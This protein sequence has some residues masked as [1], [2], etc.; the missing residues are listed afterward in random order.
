MALTRL[1]CHDTHYDATDGFT[2]TPGMRLTLDPATQSARITRLTNSGVFSTDE[3]LDPAAPGPIGS[4]VPNTGAFT[5]LLADTDKPVFHR[6]NVLGTVSQ[7]GGDPTGAVVERGNNANGRYVRF[8]D[9]TQ[10]CTYEVTFDT[11][12]SPTDT[13]TY[14]YPASFNGGFP[15]YVNVSLKS[16][17]AGGNVAVIEDLASLVRRSVTAS[18]TGSWRF[19]ART[20]AGGDIGDILLNLY[21]FGRWY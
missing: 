18:D 2:Y 5:T 12:T 19:R 8:A 20:Y 1:Y 14:P 11:G 15:D 13:K 21:A 16:A 4:S 17:A 9:G 6:G 10:I 3:T 7:S